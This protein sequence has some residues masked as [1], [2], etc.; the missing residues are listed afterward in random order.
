VKEKTPPPLKEGGG[1]RYHTTSFE[2]KIWKRG[3][4]K[5]KKCEKKTKN[6][7]KEN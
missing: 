5:E 3:M 7:N 2:M 1:R 6:K 4:K